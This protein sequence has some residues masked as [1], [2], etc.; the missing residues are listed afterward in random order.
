ME[1][2]PFASIRAL[3]DFERSVIVLSVLKKYS[4]QECATLSG[5]SLQEL[6][7]TRVR[8]LQN[9][10]EYERRDAAVITDLSA[11]EVGAR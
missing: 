2:A 11:E 3:E 9:V 7:D 5:I 10:A 1:Y 4:D 8:A 6:R